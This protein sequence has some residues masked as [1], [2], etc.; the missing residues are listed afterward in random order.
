MERREGQRGRSL[1]CIGIHTPSSDDLDATISNWTPHRY[2]EYIKRVIN[3]GRIDG[4]MKIFYRCVYYY[5]DV[6]R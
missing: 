2:V 6:A 5:S 4:R 1:S 3:D